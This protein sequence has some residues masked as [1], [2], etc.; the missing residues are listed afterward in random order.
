M[1]GTVSAGVTSSG[2]KVTDS[3]TWD[4]YGTA[5]SFTVSSGGNETVF[6]G[7]AA[8]STMV[9]SDGTESLFSGGTASFTAVSSGGAEHVYGRARPLHR[10]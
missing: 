1:S 3:E 10:S 8:I 9:S 2:I 6:S 7:G 5:V 4:I